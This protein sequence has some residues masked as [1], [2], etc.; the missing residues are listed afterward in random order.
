MAQ[1]N[2]NAF[3]IISIM[4]TSSCISRFHID[5]TPPKLSL[6]SRLILLYLVSVISLT[7]T[8]DHV[9]TRLAVC[10]DWAMKN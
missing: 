8:D 4:K 5:V 9:E 6:I 2:L 10:R 7:A 3:G 1:Q